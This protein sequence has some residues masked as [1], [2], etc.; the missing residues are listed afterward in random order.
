MAIKLIIL[1]QTITIL[2]VKPV[3]I[4]K[5]PKDSSHGSFEFFQCELFFKCWFADRQSPKL[6]L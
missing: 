1:E 4:A 3:F 6:P 5:K 2:P